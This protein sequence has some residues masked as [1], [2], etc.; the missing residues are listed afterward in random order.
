MFSDRFRDDHHSICDRLA[1]H[2][3]DLRLS[4][5]GHLHGRGPSVFLAPLATRHFLGKIVFC[6]G[7]RQIP[8]PA[9][10]GDGTTTCAERMGR[11]DVL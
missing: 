1:V 11:L 10:S 7:S 5:H 3:G 8:K 9:S 2:W 6:L 4:L